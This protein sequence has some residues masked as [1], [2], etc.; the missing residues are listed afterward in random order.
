MSSVQIEV[1]SILIIGNLDLAMPHARHAVKKN[2]KFGSH[3]YRPLAVAWSLRP[4][5]SWSTTDP[6]TSNAL[7]AIVALT[8]WFSELLLAVYTWRQSGLA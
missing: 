8:R 3:C 4:S 1:I 7:C 5:P 2:P 6:M